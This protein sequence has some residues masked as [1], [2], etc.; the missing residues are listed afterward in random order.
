MTQQAMTLKAMWLQQ[1][2][3]ARITYLNQ[4]DMNNIL[5]VKNSFDRS[6]YGKS[7]KPL[8]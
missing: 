5:E 3:Q 4:N 8:K 6:W 2:D 1:C 7:F